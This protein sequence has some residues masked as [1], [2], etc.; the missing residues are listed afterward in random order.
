MG[1]DLGLIDKKNWYK[2]FEQFTNRNVPIFL[3]FDFSHYTIIFDWTSIKPDGSFNPIMSAQLIDRNKS[4]SGKYVTKDLIW[5]CR[6]EGT[7]TDYK[8][9]RYLNKWATESINRYEKR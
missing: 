5:D 9:Y 4:G 7:T 8:L 2:A 3:F 6:K 1:N